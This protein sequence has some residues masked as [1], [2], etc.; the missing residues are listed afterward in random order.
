MVKTF[1]STEAEVNMGSEEEIDYFDEDDKAFVVSDEACDNDLDRTS[2]NHWASASSD[3]LKDVAAW[4]ILKEFLDTDMSFGEMQFIRDEIGSFHAYDLLEVEFSDDP[5]SSAHWES[6]LDAIVEAETPEEKQQ[7][8]TKL[9]STPSA[10]SDLPPQRVGAVEELTSIKQDVVTSTPDLPTWVVMVPPME[11]FK[12][13]THSTLPGRLCVKVENTYVIRNAWPSSHVNCFFD[14]V[15]LPLEDQSSVKHSMSIPGWY[16]PIRGPYRFD[17][18]LAHSYSK[19]ADALRVLFPFRAHAER[20]I[21]K[22]PHVPCLHNSP[23]S[24]LTSAGRGKTYM[25]GLLALDLRRTAVVEIPLPIPESIRLHKESGCNP[26]FVQL[27]VHMQESVHVENLPLQPLIGNSAWG[28]TIVAPQLKGKTGMVVQVDDNTVVVL[29]QSSESEVVVTEGI[30]ACEFGEINEVDP[31]MQTVAFFSF[32]QQKTITPVM[33]F[34]W[35]EV[36]SASGTVLQVDLG[37]KTLTFKDTLH[38]EFN[39][40]IIVLPILL[41]LRESAGAGI[42]S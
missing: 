9:T 11:D 27:S 6:V 16:H 28:I 19:Q 5:T 13:Y 3:P 18:G 24:V 1:V 2:G 20:G 17:V 42:M 39:V 30:Y 15:F 8:F 31:M 12:V 21:G 34:K 7:V 4:R 32:S 38:T 37:E 14:I 36:L 33:L 40:M 29:D 23:N 10:A 35:S 41:M 25:H 22:D 26:A